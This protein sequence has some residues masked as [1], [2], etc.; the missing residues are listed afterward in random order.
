MP[1]TTAVDLTDFSH[2]LCKKTTQSAADTP[3]NTANKMSDNK[4]T[5]CMEER[6]IGS[7]AQNE[8]K[9]DIG[10]LASKADNGSELWEYFD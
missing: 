3:C 2:W 5:K 10:K 9:K 4:C 6:D 8:G 7:I 1:E